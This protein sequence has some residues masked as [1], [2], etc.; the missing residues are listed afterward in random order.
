MKEKRQQASTRGS[1]GSH[2]AKFLDVGTRNERTTRPDYDC[3]FDR[4]VSIHL[5]NGYL[6][7][8]RHSWTKSVDWRIVDCDHCNIIF[9]MNSYK[10]V[11]KRLRKT[12]LPEYFLVPQ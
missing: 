12:N 8:L 4:G 3:S 2:L 6:D 11:H 1:A 5:I 7:R 10:V 9:S